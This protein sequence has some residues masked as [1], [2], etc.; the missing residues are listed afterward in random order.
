[1]SNT[2]PLVPLVPPGWLARMPSAPI[3]S[4]EGLGWR[5]LCA[6]RVKYPASFAL[7]LPATGGHFLS[8]HLHNPCEL[9]ARWNGFLRRCRSLPGEA[10][11][12][13]AQQEN[14]WEGSGAID[15]LQI[16]LDAGMLAAAGAELSDRP[17][18]LSQGIGIRDPLI[19]VIGARLVEELSHPGEGS[20]LLGDALA[21]AL[22]AQLLLRHSNLRTERAIERIDMPLHRVRAAVEYIETH[23]G[24]DLTIAMIGS[25]VQMSAFRFARGFK[26]ATGCTPHRF[27]TERRIERAKELLR[28]G[29][30]RL[31]EIAAR[32]G[33]ATQSHFAAAFRRHCRC[34]PTQYRRWVRER[35]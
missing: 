5:H 13:A 31:M 10:I 3:L 12:M 24:E 7:D 19:P 20:R 22:I 4:S 23:L 18:E 14:R 17:V 21:H 27:L 32:T 9:R 25:A 6:Y 8:C 35:G 26:R 33:F 34:S 11:I 2:A 1:V 30:L 28:A 15:E 29:E 16:F